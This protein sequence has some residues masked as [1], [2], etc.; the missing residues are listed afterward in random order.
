[1]AVAREIALRQLSVRDR[2]RRELE[3]AL[4][5]RHVPAE[6]AEQVLDRLT[7]VG[8]INDSA[9]AQAWFDTQQRRQ[10][11]TRALRHELRSKGID[12]EVVEQVA[13]NR[14]DDADLEAARA[15][16]A[17][18]APAL[19]RLPHEV[20]YRRLAGQLARRGFSSAVVATVLREL[21]RGDVADHDRTATFGDS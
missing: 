17:K 8:L 10:R 3:M 15:L 4:A 21:P 6:V 19:Q 13:S 20:R 18:R 14:A 2:S 7:E 12:A 16:V 1:M 11:S 5:K 9:F